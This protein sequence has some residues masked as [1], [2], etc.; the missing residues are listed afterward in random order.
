MRKGN[1][2]ESYG[3]G[4]GLAVSGYGGGYRPRPRR[5]G[6][7]LT[8]LAVAVLAAGTATGVTLSLDHPAAGSAAAMPLPGAA[9]VPSPAA[10]SSSG[11]Q[12]GS[13]GG[14]EQQVV[15]KVEPGLVV[16]DTT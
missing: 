15:N 10:P 14:S 5:G 16:I 3:D 13:Q 4:S 9:A 8:H 6:S 1:G 11:S 12:G 2:Y 7:V